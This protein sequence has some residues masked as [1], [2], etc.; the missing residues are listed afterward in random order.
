MPSIVTDKRFKRR[1][2]RKSPD[3][4]AAIART[5]KLLADDPRHPG[6]SAHRVQGTDGVWEA[7]VDRSNRVTFE[8]GPGGEIAMRNHCSHDIISRSP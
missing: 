6:L 1:M 4:Q 5:I 7:Y 3:M 2:R 8:Y